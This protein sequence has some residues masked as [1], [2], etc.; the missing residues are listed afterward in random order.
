M[1]DKNFKKDY[2]KA[3]KHADVYGIE[4]FKTGIDWTEGNEIC[5]IET[6]IGETKGKMLLRE[7]KAYIS[8]VPMHE[9]FVDSL[10][11]GDHR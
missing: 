11:V 3:I 9:I 2:Q 10:H 6:T 8:A 4:W 5:E 7:G 1:A